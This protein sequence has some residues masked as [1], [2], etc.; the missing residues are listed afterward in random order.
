MDAA[1]AECNRWKAL[2]E[3]HKALLE[4]TA[5]NAEDAES[6]Y[7]RRAWSIFTSIPL[8][9]KALKDARDVDG[10]EDDRF[11]DW[12][13]KKCCQDCWGVGG[14]CYCE[15]RVP[16]SHNINKGFITNASLYFP[17]QTAIMH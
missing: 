16:S 12:V 4:N 1:K 11:R 15:V 14:I 10:N 17:V 8:D 7:M 3:A 9:E 2:P 6:G 13:E 5:M